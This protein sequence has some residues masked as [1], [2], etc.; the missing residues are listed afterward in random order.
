MIFISSIIEI[1]NKKLIS[2]FA[3]STIYLNSA[4]LFPDAPYVVYY[5]VEFEKIEM[6]F[7]NRLVKGTTL[8]KSIF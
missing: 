7:L 4:F 6:S 2:K 1:F 5:N 8:D 3:D